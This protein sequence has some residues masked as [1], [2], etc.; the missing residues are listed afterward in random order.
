M[1]ALDKTDKTKKKQQHANNG[2]NKQNQATATCQY[3]TKQRNTN[4]SNVT[5]LDKTNDSNVA[6]L[7]KTKKEQQ[8][9]ITGQNKQ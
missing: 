6:V 8:H 1:T 3:W 7:D 5:A 9:D 2:Q 4:N